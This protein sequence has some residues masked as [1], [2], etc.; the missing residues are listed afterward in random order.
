MTINPHEEAIIP[1]FL[2]A[3][4]EYK[5]E[6]SILLE[7][8]NDEKSGSLIGGRVIVNFT[9][10]IVPVYILI[11]RREIIIPLNKVLENDYLVVTLGSVDNNSMS[12]DCAKKQTVT[13][14]DS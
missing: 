8:R 11:V 6:E 7:P 9:S 14:I 5:K 2:Y 4:F 3:S 10:S 12:L 13:A 1:A